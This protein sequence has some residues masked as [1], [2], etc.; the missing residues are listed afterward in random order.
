ML[1]R[2]CIHNIKDM[3]TQKTSVKG[4][5]HTIIGYYDGKIPA[6]FDDICDGLYDYLENN[7]YCNLGIWIEEA[8]KWKNK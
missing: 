6:Y 1:F 8:A 3:I 4:N 7:G 2:S 5:P